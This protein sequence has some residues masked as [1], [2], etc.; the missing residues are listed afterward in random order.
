MT[1]RTAQLLA[2]LGF[3]LVLLVPITAQGVPG[4]PIDT[5]EEAIA[6]V[7][8]V[9]SI[10]RKAVRRAVSEKFSVARMADAYLALYEDILAAKPGHGPR[11]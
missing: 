10:D 2:A 5:V 9:G 6:A 7:D 3:L 8:A 1:R 11:R 4:F